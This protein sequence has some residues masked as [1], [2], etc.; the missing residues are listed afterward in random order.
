[1]R[2]FTLGSG[3]G[4]VMGCS[5]AWAA[6]AFAFPREIGGDFGMLVSV[7]RSLFCPLAWECKVAAELEEEGK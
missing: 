2:G 1:L 7:G 6:G 4:E 3:G 5:R